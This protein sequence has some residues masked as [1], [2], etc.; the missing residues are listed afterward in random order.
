MRHFVR[1]WAAPRRSTSSCCRSSSKA[2]SKP[3]WNWPPSSDSTR[4]TRCFSIS[5]PKASASC[6]TPSKPTCA[7]RICSAV[8]IA[9]QGIAKPAG[10]IATDEPAAAGKGPAAGASER[11]SGTQ[12]HAKSNRPGRRWKKR[13]SSLALTSKYKSEFLANMSHELRTPL[14]SLLILSDQ[15]SEKPRRQPHAEANGIRQDDP[16]LRQR[17][18]DAHQRHSR[19]VEDRI[20]HGGA[21][22]RR[23]AICAICYSYVERTFRHVAEAKSVEFGVE[24]DPNLPAKPDQTDASGCNRLSKTCSPTRSNSPIMAR[25]ACECRKPT[26]A[27]IPTTKSL[28]AGGLRAGFLGNRHGHR[29][30]GGQAAD[31]LRGVSTGRRQHEPQVRRHGARPGHQSRNRRGCLEARSGCRA[32]R[33]SVAHSRCTCRK[34]SRRKKPSA[35]HRPAVRKPRVRVRSNRKPGVRSERARP[36]ALDRCTAQ[37]RTATRGRPTE[38]SKAGHAATAGGRRFDRGRRKY[39]RPSLDPNR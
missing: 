36:R 24:L 16:L 27:G 39:R 22:C 4:R 14:N 5:S 21:G 1:A 29:H 9:R 37:R 28:N 3:F 32:R 15:L 30:P 7:R 18:A 8:A 34:V 33:A 35:V 20:R 2:R 11:R 23:V 12:E 6:S 17:S 25:F 26:A 19:S 10:R 31:H 13:P 38:C